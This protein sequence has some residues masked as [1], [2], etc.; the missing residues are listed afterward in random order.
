MFRAQNRPK[1]IHSP[2]FMWPTKPRSTFGSAAHPVHTALRLWWM[3][4]PP[5]HVWMPNHPHATMARS[6]EGML[7]PSRPNEE[8]TSTGNGTP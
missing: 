2:R 4:E 3:A 6:S 7:A 1:P 5:I 8:R